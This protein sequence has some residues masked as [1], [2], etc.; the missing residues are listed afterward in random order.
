MPT[1]RKAHRDALLIMAVTLDIGKGAPFSSSL[2]VIGGARF[3]LSPV[4]QKEAISMVKV[5]GKT[6]VEVAELFNVDR[7]TISRLVSERRVLERK[8]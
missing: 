3:K 6:Q 8:A 1:D 2:N 5:S 7:S 4:Q